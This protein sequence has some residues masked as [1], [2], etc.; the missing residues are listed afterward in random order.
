[1]WVLKLFLV[2]Q[3]SKF[4]TYFGLNG[5]E[6]F[7]IFS[8]IEISDKFSALFCIPA[9]LKILLQNI[10]T[11]KKLDQ[12]KSWNT[13]T[14]PDHEISAAKKLGKNIMLPTHQWFWFHF[15]RLQC[16]F[17]IQTSHSDQVFA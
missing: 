5:T 11:I 7:V 4:C 14:Y 16:L 12:V 8:F 6:A 1:M 13:L 10:L 17:I 2:T 9:E 3:L 15:E